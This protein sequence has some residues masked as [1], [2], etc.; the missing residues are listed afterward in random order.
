MKKMA[1]EIELSRAEV[2]AIFIV[3]LAFLASCIWGTFGMPSIFTLMDDLRHN[4]RQNSETSA[5][6]PAAPGNQ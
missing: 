2:V 1:E 6:K 4:L 3:G 5:S